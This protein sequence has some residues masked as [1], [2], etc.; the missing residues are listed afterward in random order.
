MLLTDL[1]HLLSAQAEWPGIQ[2]DD[3]GMREERKSNPDYE[4]PD[5]QEVESCAPLTPSLLLITAPAAVGKSV[6]AAYISHT[7]HAP[8]LDLSKLQVGDGTLEGSMAKSLG[9]QRNAKFSQALT[10]ARA[11]L[12]IDA[13]DEAEVRS[14]QANFKAFIRGV[15]HTASQITGGPAIAVFSRAESARSLQ[16]VFAERR[17]QYAH[18]EI[19]PF[20]KEQ[21]ERYLDR[22]V[23]EAYRFQGKE[24][25]HKKHPQPFRLA[26]DQLFST[27]ASTLSGAADDV[28]QM[29]DVRDFL[30]YAPVLDV[31]AEYLAVDN[32]TTLTKELEGSLGAGLVQHWNIVANVI[33]QLLVREHSKLIEQFR[34]TAEFTQHGSSALE[35]NLYTPEEQCARLLDYIENLLLEFQIPLTLPSELREPYESA[36][37]AQLVNHPFL[38]GESWFNVIF[39]DYVTARCLI[40]P[41]TPT[42][43]RQAIRKKLLSREWKHSPM[44]GYFSYSLGGVDNRESECH[45][46]V[47]GALYESFKSM[48][49]A[50]DELSVTVGKVGSRLVASYAVSRHGSNMSVGPLRFAAYEGT[51]CISFPRELSN[52]DFWDVPAVILGGDHQSFR[53]GPDVHISCRD[54]LVAFGELQV[55]AQKE[56][57]PIIIIAK[58]LDSDDVK[59]HADPS[60]LVVVC[61]EGLTFPWSRYEKKLDIGKMAS[62]MREAAALYIELRRI[63]LR[64]KDARGRGVGAVYQ[65]MMDNLVVGSNRRARTVLNY[66]QQRNCVRLEKYMYLLDF[67]KFGELGLSRPQLRDLEQSDAASR[68]SSE[69]LEFSRGGAGNGGGR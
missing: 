20:N 36:A 10:E 38:R 30:G 18:Y 4:I 11:S 52:A 46:E 68:I 13:L 45:A 26:R 65:P 8:I 51:E 39:R 28:W 23:C 12:L 40:S 62:D 32:F 58:S 47:I 16:E 27:L 5:V 61:D 69:L 64:F 24:L 49:E 15:A 2:S 67:A 7:L 17:L 33:D 60:D 29:P 50:T 31:A 48:C 44:F 53:F 56:N 6:A 42:E 66:L 9:I 54:L 57:L 19:Q 3:Y 55:Y 34:R 14:G 43:S 37:E 63:I 59:I 1:C 41:I 21:A 35:R 22:K 25:V